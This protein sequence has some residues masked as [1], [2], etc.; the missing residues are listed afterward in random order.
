MNGRAATQWRRLEGPLAAWTLGHG[1][2]L[3]FLHGFTQTAISWQP[4]AEALA[5]ACPSYECVIVDL[6]GHG[7]SASV[8][9]D[10]RSGGD[11]IAGFGPAALI[12]YSMGGR[13]ALHTAF[14]HPTSVRAL[15]VLGATAGIEDDLERAARRAADEALALRLGEIG[16]EAFL[17]E[18]VTQPLFGSWRPSAPDWAARLTNTV[19]GLASSLRLAGTGSQLPLWSR[20]RELTMPV[21]A[22]AGANDAKFAPI[23]AQLA[24]GVVDGR[25]E[26]IPGAAH[27]A[28]LEQPRRVLGALTRLLQPPRR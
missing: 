20:L 3:V 6:P 25:C 22:M 23:A 9:A 27:A 12:G 14:A 13:F 7:G 16:V 21:L 18:W 26:L 4:I 2:R 1:P 10:L 19:D 5:T 28:Q 24:G 11:M 15:A 8:R 17:R